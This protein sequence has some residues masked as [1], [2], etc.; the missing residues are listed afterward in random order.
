MVTRNAKM[1]VAIAGVSGY[2]GYELFRMLSRHRGAQ[3]SAMT[4]EQA[5]GLGLDQVFDQVHPDQGSGVLLQRL[6]DLR[7]Q[8]ID[9]VFLCLPH[10][11]AADWVAENQS[12]LP[13]VIDLSADFRLKNA[14]DY[15]KW[16]G[17]KHPAAELLAT[18][19]YGLTEFNGKEISQ[20]AFIANPGCYPTAVMLGLVPLLKHGLVDVNATI[21]ID[22]KSGVSGAGRKASLANGFVEVN[23][24]LAP[25]GVGNSHRHVPEIA[26]GLTQ[27]SGKAVDFVFTPHLIPISR[28]MLITMYVPMSGE[29][30]VSLGSARAVLEEEFHGRPFVRVLPNGKAASVAHVARTNY[31]ALS[32]H[33]SGKHLV[34]VS[35]IDNLLK[36]ASGQ[37]LQN[38]NISRGF[39]EAEGIL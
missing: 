24:N 36:G 6:E 30:D 1:H 28:G 9:T 34:V 26:Q 7:K 22:A 12:A 33:Q 25:Y 2:T 19:V 38:F 3:I 29:A 17:F 21:M 31:C 4:S 16:Y 18:A 14:V 11:G 15:D 23:E 39:S 20:S 27:F 8:Q 5:A 10:R 37:A 35:A 32:V 13:Q